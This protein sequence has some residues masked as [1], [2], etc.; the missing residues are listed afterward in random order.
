LLSEV[1]VEQEQA[2]LALSGGRSRIRL[3]QLCATGT[4]TDEAG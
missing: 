4:L 3:F 2:S 1:I